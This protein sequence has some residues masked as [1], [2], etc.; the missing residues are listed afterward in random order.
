MLVVISVQQFSPEFKRDQLF[1][2]LKMFFVENDKNFKDLLLLAFVIS[3]KE[4][5]LQLLPYRPWFSDIDGKKVGKWA[6]FYQLFEIEACHFVFILEALI[7]YFKVFE[8]PMYCLNIGVL[9]HFNEG[10]VFY[11]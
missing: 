2:Q 5:N 3:R 11:L 9:E 8:V 10:L 7:L 4:F 6:F 1:Q